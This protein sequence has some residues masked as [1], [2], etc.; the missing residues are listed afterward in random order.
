MSGEARPVPALTPEQTSVLMRRLARVA[1]PAARLVM[2][3]LLDLDHGDGSFPGYR[4][5]ADHAGIS[6]GTARHALSELHG[7]GALVG[8]RAPGFGSL[9]IYFAVPADAWG[10]HV[11][12]DVHTDSVNG[13][14]HTAPST[15]DLDVNADVNGSVNVSVNASRPQYLGGDGSSGPELGKKL[16]A[17]AG[18]LAEARPVVAL[19]TK[20]LPGDAV[21]DLK[22]RMREAKT[23]AE[24]EFFE[25]AARRATGG[26]L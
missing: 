9:V 12:G 23:D 16:L 4:A 10:S 21:A 18:A 1:S 13:D 8:R 3:R 15:P 24:R 22:R 6:P 17:P 20:A 19:T 14:D 11:N 2:R 5:L 26:I 25:K 7:L